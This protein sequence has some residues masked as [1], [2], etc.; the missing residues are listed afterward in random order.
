MPTVTGTLLNA[1]EPND[2][3]FGTNNV[4]TRSDGTYAT[5]LNPGTYP[6]R[7]NGQGPSGVDPE[8]INVMMSPVHQDIS[9]PAY[10]K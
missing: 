5:N 3:R 1:T 6:I 10:V 9:A 4:R 2:L 7:V 8:S